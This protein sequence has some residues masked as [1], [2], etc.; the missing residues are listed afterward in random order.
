VRLNALPLAQAP[1]VC[2]RVVC[3]I[4]GYAEVREAVEKAGVNVLFARTHAGVL[5]YGSDSHVRAAFEPHGITDFDLHTIETKRLR[6]ESGERGLLREA[7]TRAIARERGM[8]RIRR[9][10]IDLLA[11]TDLEHA[12]WAPLRRLLGSLSGSVKDPAE[13]QWCE[14]MGTRLEWDVPSCLRLRRPS[15]PGYW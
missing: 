1:T 14:G 8:N 3:Q 2:R 15:C 10:N 11:P 12:A 9:R 6:Y 7:L 5:A 13:L 4:G